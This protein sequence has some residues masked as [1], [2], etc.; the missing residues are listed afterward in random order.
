MTRIELGYTL[1]N[2]VNAVL[3]KL[4]DKLKAEEEMLKSETLLNKKM[5]EQIDLEMLVLKKEKGLR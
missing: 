1:E 4:E 5:I 3:D 2:A